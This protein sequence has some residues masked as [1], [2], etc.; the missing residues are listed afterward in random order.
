MPYPQGAS[1]EEDPKFMVTSDML[2]TLQPTSV[3][4][5]PK[6]KH[7]PRPLHPVILFLFWSA[8]PTI[9]SEMAD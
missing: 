8:Q 3:R 5:A 6:A 9:I 4:D 2:K 7:T 1:T